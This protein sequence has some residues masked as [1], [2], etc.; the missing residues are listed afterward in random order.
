MKKTVITLSVVLALVGLTT[1]LFAL[2]ESETT[3]KVNA[4]H[5]AL[6]TK[7]DSSDLLSS[8]TKHFVKEILLPLSTNSIFAEAAEA[9]NSKSLSLD[10]I[11]EIDKQWVEAEEELQI[12]QD[13]MGNKCAKEIIRI[14]EMMP[15]IGEV[16]V[17]D[18]Q[19]ANVGQNALTSDYWQGDEAKWENS[20][21]A[22]KG[23]VDIAKE[24][25]D[26]STDLVDQKVSIPVINKN[27][28]VVGA[29]CFGVNK[30]Y[31]EKIGIV[32][33]N[34]NSSDKLSDKLKSYVKTNLISIITNKTF[35]S[36]VAGQNDKAVSL[37]KIKQI[38]ESWI[39]AEDVLPIHDELMSNDCA[40]EVKMIIAKNPSI[41]EAF[42]MDNQG[43]NVG[44]NTL[45]SDYWQGDE[46][47]WKNSYN[48][49]KGGIEIGDVKFD[50][51]ADAQLQ[52][53]S[54]PVINAKG[55]V[56]GAI[57]LGIN[58]DQVGSIQLASDWSVAS[59]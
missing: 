9:Q 8:P 48:E 38:D 51:S 59:K 50:K 19:G 3:E 7:V 55:N 10:K 20:Y 45:T 6:I 17:M 41:T 46:A 22:G 18:N 5:K 32:I 27:G 30:N 58:T 14:T 2:S 16:F 47:K 42:V 15:A 34:V 37:D 25:L 44:Q 33:E 57:C 43:A 23:G 1:N 54:L 24:K 35:A 13:M 29:I 36:A 39:N 4:L 28:D 56:I 11:K 52:Q 49:G 53:I 40:K 12:H 31:A 21:N 26:K